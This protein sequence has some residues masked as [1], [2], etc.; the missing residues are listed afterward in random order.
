MHA[1]SISVHGKATII[2]VQNARKLYNF[3]S[4][5]KGFNLLCF[6]SGAFVVSNVRL[7]FVQSS[8]I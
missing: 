5:W 3:R 1:V 4:H 8:S 7:T 2:D 6:A